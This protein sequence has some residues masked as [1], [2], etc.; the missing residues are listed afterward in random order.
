M[1]KTTVHF[2]SAKSMSDENAQQHFRWSG[3]FG[4]FSCEITATHMANEVA[5]HAQETPPISSL[6][7]PATMTAST[8]AL[9]QAVSSVDKTISSQVCKRGGIGST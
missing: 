9:A 2:E 3:D 7:W 5:D 8:T 6:S 4:S 1:E